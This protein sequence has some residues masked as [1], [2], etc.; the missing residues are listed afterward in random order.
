MPRYPLVVA[1][2]LL[3][4]VGLLG[5]TPVTGVSQESPEL[6]QSHQE[7]NPWANSSMEVEV[8]SDGD[9][10]WN[11]SATIPLDDEQDVETFESMASDFESGQVSAPGLQLATD[12]AENVDRRTDRSVEI[13]EIDRNST[14]SSALE[15][16]E[17][18]QLYVEFT[19]ENF[20]RIGDDRLFVDDVLIMTTGEL[21]LKTLPRGQT[22]VMVGPEG[23]GVQASPGPDGTLEANRLRWE[24]PTTF[25]QSNLEATFI[26]T[27][28]PPD[29]NGSDD[30][31]DDETA[32]DG[33][34][35]SMWWLA[36]LV[37]LLGL[38]AVVVAVRM[39]D[40]EVDFPDGG[41]EAKPA[42]DGGAGAAA[43][44]AQTESEPEPEPE[45]DASEPDDEIDTELLSDGERV[46]RLLE[47][48]G[49][50]MKQATIVKETDWSDAKVSQLLSTMEEEDRIDKLRIGRENLI[51]FPD[52][53]ITEIDE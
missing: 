18:A 39:A 31:D 11:I 10:R 27:T 25:E 34:G 47:Q 6:D 52:E 24:G 9:A 1:F 35:L 5:I 29:D 48:N 46:E 40:L 15:P 32:N 28:T 38:V 20:A 43:A 2:V 45:P 22:F 7:W 19:W 26:G 41:T 13:T 4:C 37:V 17:T 8:Q 23:Y 44:A 30:D 21:W 51:S 49:G 14:P 36:I 53:D 50:R 42:D 16:G 12:A 33:G 3:L